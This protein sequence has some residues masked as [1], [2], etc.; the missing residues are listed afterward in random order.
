MNP[1]C[2]A[3]HNFNIGLKFQLKRQGFQRKLYSSL[4]NQSSNDSISKIYLRI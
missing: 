4:C 3:D 1:I 2:D